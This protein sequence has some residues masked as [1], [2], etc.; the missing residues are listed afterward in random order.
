MIALICLQGMIGIA[1]GEAEKSA[2][3]DSVALT[4]LGCEMGPSEASLSDRYGTRY[5]CM[6]A[7]ARMEAVLGRGGAKA[8]ER[9]I[10]SELR[11]TY[12]YNALL[13]IHG[14]FHH[15]LL[16]IPKKSRTHDLDTDLALLQVGNLA[17][18]PMRLVIGKGQLPLGVNR[19]VFG[20]LYAK[21]TQD[22]L[23]DTPEYVALGTFDDQNQISV[24]FG[25]AG[26]I[27]PKMKKDEASDQFDKMSDKAVGLRFMY[28]FAILGSTRSVLSFYGKETGIRRSGMGLLTIGVKGG[29]THLEFMRELSTPDGKRDQFKQHIRFGYLG[30][31]ERS[32]RWSFQLDDEIKVL[33]RAAILYEQNLWD[34]VWTSFGI[35]YGKGQKSTV[36]RGWTVQ[37]GLGTPL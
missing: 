7:K 5:F 26:D 17:T 32:S 35:G 28:D 36:N 25:V 8:M 34:C 22:N 15:D 11:T 24:D 9:G 6:T 18:F 13:G 31:I 2:M 23:F 1:F 10:F 29:E 3:P 37:M 16:W 20:G 30:P 14:A 4:L 12:V 19:P 27:S 33:T 21:G